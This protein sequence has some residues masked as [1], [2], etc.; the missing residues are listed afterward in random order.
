MEV[1]L[2]QFYQT[3]ITHDNATSIS[4][5]LLTG[6]LKNFSMSSY[7]GTLFSRTVSS[8]DHSGN[9]CTEKFGSCSIVTVIFS[10]AKVE[11]G[12]FP[13]DRIEHSILRCLF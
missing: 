6:I 12:K 10:V 9:S 8:T 2:H 7:S 11:I 4:R 5:V 1:T 13:E 3:T